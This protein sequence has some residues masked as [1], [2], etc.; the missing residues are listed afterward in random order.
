MELQFMTPTEVWEGFLLSKDPL[1]ESIISAT[2]K[3]NILCTSLCFTSENTPDGKVRAYGEIYYDKRWK[4]DRSAILLVPALSTNIKNSSLIE[5]LVKNGY[6]VGV[7]DYA[8]ILPDKKTTYP[9]SLAS[10]SFPVCYDHMYSIEGSAKSSPWFIWSKIVR[11][12]LSALSNH[13][14][15]DANRIGIMGIGVGAQIAWQVAGIDKR[16]AA[17]VTINGNG[18]LWLKNKP[19]FS[20]SNVPS[21]DNERAFS[22]GVGAETYARFVNCPVCSIVPSNSSFTDPDRAGDI[23]SLAPTTSK[24]LMIYK[25]SESQLP[26]SIF[27]GLIK[28]L[29]ANC[30]HDF[31]SRNFPSI[32]FET[33]DGVLTLHLKANFKSSNTILNVSY[34]TSVPSL[35]LWNTIERGQKIGLHEYIFTIPVYNPNEMISAFVTVTSLDGL[36]MS[37]P[38]ESVIP[39]KLQATE[40]TE[41][42]KTSRIIYNNQMKLGAFM[43]STSD[44]FLDDDTLYLADGPFNLK[45]VSVKDGNLI[46]FRNDNEPYSKERSAIFQMDVYSKEKRTVN[47]TLVAPDLKEYYGK[48]NL[49]GGEFWQRVQLVAS[50][51]KSENGKTLS[52]FA[53]TKKATFKDAKDIVFNNMLWL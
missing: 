36:T 20:T 50:D 46:L 17:L 24:A 38:I 22:T 23:L 35:R 44:S 43:A 19:K 8:G 15:V 4:D 32:A 11:R 9:Q 26:S 1:E 53:D 40:I 27:D 25:S 13:H 18:Y 42:V 52:V 29:H 16:I 41:S 33:K 45:G 51:F 48:M 39:S 2:E 6:A 7:I 5:K 47:I 14:P 30:A 37:S 12:F 21:D 28:W 31:K 34:G 49:S 3:D 10:A